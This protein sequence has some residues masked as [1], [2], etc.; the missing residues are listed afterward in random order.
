MMILVNI[1]PPIHKYPNLFSSHCILKQIIR[2]FIIS[3]LL[4]FPHTFLK[5]PAVFDLLFQLAAYNEQYDICQILCRVLHMRNKE[6]K[7]SF[8]SHSAALETGK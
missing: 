3:D 1:P 2:N 7:K 4:Y 8:F 6:K 5:L